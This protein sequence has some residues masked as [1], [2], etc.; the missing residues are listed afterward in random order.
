MTPTQTSTPPPAA[1]RRAAAPGAPASALTTIDPMK[2]LQQYYP[3]LMAAGIVGIVFGIGA[4]MVLRR[5]YPVWA[6]DVTYEI[7]PVARESTDPTND[8][9]SREGMEAY[10]NTMARVAS[11]DSILSKAI[12][13]KTVRDT[14]WAEQ[15]KDASGNVDAIEALKALR[16]IVSTRVIPDTNILQLTVSTHEKDDA[17]NIARAISDVF[18]G[19]TGSRSG[20]DMRELIEQF[21]D[22]VKTLGK[23]IETIDSR[24]EALL[25]KQQLTALRQENT[26]SYSE[27]S[28]LQPVIV[29]MRDDL[30]TITQQLESYTE[31]LNNPSGPQYPE[32]IREQVEHEPI[33][34]DRDAAIASIKT[35]LR[36]MRESFGENH[37]E[38][39]LLIKRLNAEQTER[40]SMVGKQ[41][42]ETFSTVV[43]NL[44]NSKRNQEAS[45]EEMEERLRQATVQ[46]EDTTK[47]LKQY[48][49]WAT[50]RVEKVQKKSEMERNVSEMRLLLARGSRIKI[51]QQAQLPDSLAF[52]KIIPCV[53]LS[54]FLFGGLTAGI[55]ALKELREQ[56]I[57]GPHD[58]ALIPRTR[59]LGLVP[60]LDMDPSSPE[61]IEL[62]SRDRPRGIIADSVRQIRVALCKE[63]HGRGLRSVMI[64]GGLPGSGASSLIS[65]LAVNAAA[66]D[67]RVL[68]V[69][70]NLRR[71]A[72]HAI[73]GA[74]EAPG[75]ADVLMG[76]AVL[77][78]A[79]RATGVENVSILPC[80]RRDRP[81]FERYTTPAMASLF[82]ELKQRFDLVLVDS[83]PGVVS[84]DAAAIA[85]HC[86]AVVLVV[87]ALSEKRGLVLRLRNQ[88][89][90][91]GAEFLGVV[92]NA[93]KASAGG[94]FKRN[95]Q[96]SHEYGR[97]PV[98]DTDAKDRMRGDPNTPGPTETN[99]TLL[100]AET[101]GKA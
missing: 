22:V 53:A 42:L 57:R 50:E 100:A 36:S 43:E 1:A 66:T 35:A 71:P 19:D 86:D 31:M 23:D 90:E 2:V 79:I 85:S 16:K 63:L 25:S 75:L 65:N 40:D 61:R 82:H 20:R 51:L 101:N 72:L 60:E 21:E 14:A 96:V 28:S 12:E 88:L 87:R 4:F 78:S 39:Q 27:V 67:L 13:E 44:E 8:D 29:R 37:R 52:P 68:V 58:V 17:P 77:D 33:I 32:A 97:E 69:D 80:G 54:I 38:V 24:T 41:M 11:S 30:G 7:R 95:Y 59:V 81:V 45:L 89:G 70:T 73:F 15:F 9:G 47:A 84:G 91:T 98:A 94:Y 49:D 48:E 5:V 92:V 46:L 56:R 83:T 34:M 10:M 76:E 62:A 74:A 64:V 26:V 3:W 93:V 55:I 6:S 99:G 18:L